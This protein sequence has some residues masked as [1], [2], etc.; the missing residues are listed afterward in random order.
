MTKRNLSKLNLLGE[1]G[2][3]IVIG[4][5][6]KTS[7]SIDGIAEAIG[8][9]YSGAIRR[10][11]Q[12]SLKIGNKKTRL[13][14]AWEGPG[15]ENII[16]GRGT[17]N[18]K[19]FTY[20]AGVL[21]EGETIKKQGYIIHFLDRV[22][23]ETIEGTGSY[24]LSRFYC[25]V[26]L[27]KSW[28]SSLGRNKDHLEDSSDLCK[29][30][31]RICEPILKIATEESARHQVGSQTL[32]VNTALMEACIHLPSQSKAKGKK[33]IVVESIKNRTTSQKFHAYGKKAAPLLS[34]IHHQQL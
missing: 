5:A 16:E 30:L 3:T 7:K 12:I 24:S 32:N 25:E 4:K 10:G 33:K 9:H 20:R 6:R 27:D 2:T 31:F 34:S 8:Y 23:C 17:V 29:E 26:R 1:H 28:R 13:V 15:I 14:T 22:I 19:S 11:V 18:G 21:K